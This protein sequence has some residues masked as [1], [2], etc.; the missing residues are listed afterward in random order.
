[1][2]LAASA[3]TCGTIKGTSGSILKKLELSITIECLAAFL[4]YFSEIVP[5]AAKKVIFTFE[6]SNVSRLKTSCSLPLKII[7]CPALLDEATK[8]NSL[9]EGFSALKPQAFFFQHFLWLLQL[10]YS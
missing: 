5:P 8:Y 9:I 10:L 1:M 6:K 2:L 3:F 4:A 7:F